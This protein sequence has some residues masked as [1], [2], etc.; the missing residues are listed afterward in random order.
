VLRFYGYGGSGVGRSLIVVGLMLI[1]LGVLV[2]IFREILAAVAAIM[3]VLTGI[4]LSLNG[5]RI[6]WNVRQARRAEG[7]QDGAYRENVQIRN[8]DEF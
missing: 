8:R 2:F 4:G 1:G 3:L 6:L 7:N 5:I